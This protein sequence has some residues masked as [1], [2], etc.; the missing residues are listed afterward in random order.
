MLLR[1]FFCQYIPDPGEGSENKKNLLRFPELLTT[2]KAKYPDLTNQPE[3]SANTSILVIPI[4]SCSYQSDQNNGRLF[5]CTL[6]AS[7]AHYWVIAFYY[8]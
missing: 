1:N 4:I 6:R 7:R 5:V 2:F 8:F 3:R